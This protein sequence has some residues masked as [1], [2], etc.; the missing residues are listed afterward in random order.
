MR[1]IMSLPAMNCLILEIN[2]SAAFVKDADPLL[3]HR[4]EM[5]KILIAAAAFLLLFP[6]SAEGDASFMNEKPEVRIQNV[7]K[8]LRKGEPVTVIT[9]GGSITTG[10]ASNPIT[11]NSWAALTGKWFKDKAAAT[12]SILHYMNEGVS[13][14][15]SAF[16]AVRV[17]DHVTAYHPDLV[18]LEFAMNDQWLGPEVR[19][20]TYE[21]VIRQIM[22]GTDCAILALFVNERNPP[23]P[24][25]QYEQQPVCE[26]YHIPFVS[27]KDCV[28]A[29]NKNTDWSRF[30][31][32]EETIHP[33]NAGHASIANYITAELESYYDT[34][35]AD[36]AVPVPVKQLR[37]ALTDTGFQFVMYY[38]MDD[39]VPETDTGWQRGSPVHPEWVQHGHVKQGWQTDN[40][41]AAMTFKVTGSSIGITYC[42]SDQFRNADAWVTKPDGTDS[43]HVM[44]ECCNSIRNGYLG[45]AYREIVSGK[46]VETYTLHVAIKKRGK[47]GTFANITGIVAAGKTGL[48]K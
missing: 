18:I 35:P 1:T 21:G 5:K 45:W 47:P 43:P 27:W 42:E 24:G 29:D 19:R 3:Y 23:F 32:G 28:V 12:G 9:L 8:K 16:A 4:S 39:I 48:D 11:E 2:E 38:S 7:L 14:T 17:K 15:D 37:E 13:G 26:Y 34:L 46:K 41:D 6:L 33:N 10:F 36:D 40:P 22:D 44:L 20:R 30:F 31:D 25:Q